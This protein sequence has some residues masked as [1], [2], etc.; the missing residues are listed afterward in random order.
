M[1]AQHKPQPP[2]AHEALQHAFAVLQRPGWPADLAGAMAHPIYSV[3]VRGLARSRQRKVVHAPLA[4]QAQ[5]P[6]P[7]R[8]HALHKPAAAPCFDSKRAAA[9]DLDD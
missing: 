4:L 7:L 3:A 8:G 6:Q 1:A 5:V 2:L 9:N